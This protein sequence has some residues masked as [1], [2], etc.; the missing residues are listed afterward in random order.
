[1]QDIFSIDK[2]NYLFKL[3]ELQ[4]RHETFMIGYYFSLITQNKIFVK[5]KKLLEITISL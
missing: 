3:S 1:M 5:G 2:T 4:Y